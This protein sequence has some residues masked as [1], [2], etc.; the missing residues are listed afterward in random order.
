MLPEEEE[1]EEEETTDHL[2]FKCKILRTQRNEMIKQIYNT[3][4]KWPTT[5]E[6]LVNNYS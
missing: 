2:I 4:G 3:G 1:E 6:T 5:N